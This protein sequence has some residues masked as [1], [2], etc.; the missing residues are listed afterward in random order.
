MPKLKGSSCHVAPRAVF[1][2]WSASGVPNH[3]MPEAEV[4]VE[5]IRGDLYAHEKHY[6]CHRALSLFDL[7]RDRLSNIASCQRAV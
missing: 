1:V 6:R 4:T 3:P 5:G 2:C 7:E